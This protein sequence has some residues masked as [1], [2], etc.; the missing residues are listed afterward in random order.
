MSG[1]SGYAL[2]I[3]GFV[4]VCGLRWGALRSF[5]FVWFVIGRW[6]S[7]GPSRCAL[8]VA[9]LLLVRLVCPGTLWVLRV[10][11]GFVW[12]VRVRRGGR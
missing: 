9:R 12:F 4:L 1:S 7:S 10:Q 11:S 6:C 3:V 8:V 2:E 5:G